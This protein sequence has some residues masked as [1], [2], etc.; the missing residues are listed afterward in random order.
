MASWMRNIKGYIDQ[1]GLAPPQLDHFTF[2]G[3]P[4]KIANISM[5]MAN[6][7]DKLS[8]LNVDLEKELLILVK[9]ADGADLKKSPFFYMAQHKHA[10]QAVC[11]PFSELP[12]VEEVIRPKVSRVSNIFLYS[13]DVR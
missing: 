2:K 1:V 3:E 11:I 13:T 8:V 6:F 7:G 4:E 12:E 9:T 10:V 5:F